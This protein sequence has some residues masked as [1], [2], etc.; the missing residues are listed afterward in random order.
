VIK[1]STAGVPCVKPNFQKVGS[2]IDRLCGLVIR[3][4]GYRSRGPRFD[5]WHY[6]IFL[7]AV[8]R[9]SLSLMRINEELLEIKVAAQV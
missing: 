7:G 4:P 3:V 2:D 5:T 9:G 8:E 1:R 6:Q